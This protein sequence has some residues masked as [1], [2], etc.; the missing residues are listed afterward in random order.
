MAEEKSKRKRGGGVKKAP[1]GYYMPREAREKL[2]MT[3][4]S[5][6]YYVRQGKIKKH[7]PPLRS[8]GFYDKKEI[9]RLATE[10]A[11]FIHEA[12]GEQ[13]TETRVAQPTDAQGIVDVLLSFGWQTATADQRRSWYRVNPYQ[14]Y[15]VVRDGQVTGYIWA[16][17]LKA[18]ALE[19]MMSGR[20][21]GW[22]IQP[23][24]ILPYE[25][26]RAYNLYIGIATRKDVEQHTQRV[27]FRL[28]SGFFTFLEELGE[29]GILIHQ[30]YAVSAESEGQKLCRD[31]GFIQQPAQEGDK[32]PRFMLDLRTSDSHFAKLYKQAVQSMKL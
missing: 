6:N 24:D 26:G 7:V 11:L 30:L 18:E 14:D 20:K 29:Q 15:V 21:R 32:F 12:T 23:Q 19:D 25:P 17:P 22:H 1:P 13:T 3:E 5:F 8:E 27:G 31:L 4:S 2:G 28:I 10:M 16:V 9:D